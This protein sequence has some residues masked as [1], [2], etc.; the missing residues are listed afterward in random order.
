MQRQRELG[1]RLELFAKISGAHEVGGAH[2][3]AVVREQRHVRVRAACLEGASGFLAGRALWSDIVG[4]SDVR[5]ELR[6][7]SVDRLKALGDIVEE[8]ARPRH[9]WRSAQEV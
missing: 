7:R 5:G 2:D 4:S 8:T 1:G 9:E 3:A 6:A